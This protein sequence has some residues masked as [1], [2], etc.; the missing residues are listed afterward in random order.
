MAIGHKTAVS[1]AASRLTLEVQPFVEPV[2]DSLALM[3]TVD[4]FLD[5]L[6]GSDSRG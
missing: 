5:T 2:F 3:N 6:R 1:T 4:D